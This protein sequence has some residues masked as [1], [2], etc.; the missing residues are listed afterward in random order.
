MSATV[1]AQTQLKDYFVPVKAYFI[2][3][4]DTKCSKMKGVLLIEVRMD[5]N[6][7]L[8]QV[9]VQLWSH[10]ITQARVLD[11]LMPQGKGLEGQSIGSPAGKTTPA[12]SCIS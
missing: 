10:R 4:T 9:G 8:N 3:G 5:I 11:W 2:L 12:K 7:D 1:L 6:S